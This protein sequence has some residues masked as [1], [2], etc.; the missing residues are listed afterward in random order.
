M[1][2]VAHK[3]QMQELWEL[4][5]TEHGTTEATLQ[6]VAE[7]AV[8]G[9]HWED[10]KSAVERCRHAFRSA[11]NEIKDDDGDRVYINAEIEQ[12]VFWANRS[13]A[14][15]AMRKRFLDEQCRRVEA[16]IESL[17]RICAKF[18]SERR[19][20]EPEFQLTFDW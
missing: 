9:G 4:Y 13:H 20:G 19:D 12:Q 3:K 6:E 18:N 14:S 16:D 1:L 11:L 7:W 10:P 17:K 5:L 8:D 2:K 15:H